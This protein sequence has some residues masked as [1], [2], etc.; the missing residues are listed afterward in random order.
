MRTLVRYLLLQLPGWCGVL[1]V[2]WLLELFW[3][4]PIWLGAMLFAAFVA[5]DLVLF[6]FLRHAYSDEPSR[7]IGPE[8]LIGARGVAEEDLAPRGFVR[9][10]GE[11]WRADGPA[12]GA[13]PISRGDPV[14]VR[15]VRGLTVEVELAEPAVQQS[16]DT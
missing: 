6:P 13:T 11:R 7:M 5:K 15:A 3:Q 1:L 4:L 14:V 16:A 10:R 8:R 12:S 2:L 9:V